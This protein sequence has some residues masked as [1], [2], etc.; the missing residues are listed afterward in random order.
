[1]SRED[2][3]IAHGDTRA[4]GFSL[5]ESLDEVSKLPPMFPLELQKRVYKDPEVYRMAHAAELVA[6]FKGWCTA[7]MDNRDDLLAMNFR[8]GELE[9]LLFGKEKDK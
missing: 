5:M 4:S 2:A 8:F 7:K 6:F 1:M 9:T 3:A